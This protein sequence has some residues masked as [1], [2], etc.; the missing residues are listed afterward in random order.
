M[1]AKG[2]L[3][4]NIIIAAVALAVL[5]GGYYFAVQWEPKN[6]EA[7][8]AETADE[9]NDTYVISVEMQDIS[10]LHIKNTEA[11][12]DIVQN[13]DD[14]SVASMNNSD[15][16]RS[17]LKSTIGGLSKLKAVREIKD[18]AS[19][20]ADFGLDKENVLYTIKASDGTEA[21]VLLGNEVPSGGEFYCMV[22]GGD[23]IYTIGS[24]QAGYITKKPDDYR[25][26]SVVS[27]GDVSSI[28]SFA[29]YKDGV[30]VF[31]TVSAAAKDNVNA[32]LMNRWVIEHPWKENA[33]DDKL[34][35]LLNTFASIEAVGFADN[36]DISFDYRVEITAG[37]TEYKLNVG[38]AADGGVYLQNDKNGNIYIVD[39]GIRER[40]EQLNPNDYILKIVALANID[41]VSAVRVKAANGE[42]VLEPGNEDGAPYKINGE[43]VDEKSFKSKYQTVI[44]VLFRERGEFN[45][46][47]EPYMTITYAYKNGSE[48]VVRY[49]EYDDRD[50]V[51]VRND[52]TTVKLLRSE[53]AKIEK[54]ISDK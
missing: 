48:A 19:K 36:A 51:A 9:K 15:I 41:E 20:T 27:I 14:I 54:L 31:K 37:G 26:T 32:S 40:L 30:P 38:G 21:T 12:Y 47:G 33:S 44:G 49:Y 25:I 16:N 6:I 17:A 39:K 45:V 10:V 50:L 29:V 24:S 13:G 4:R 35:E 22:R 46:S 23:R 5:G 52:G 3:I 42:Y 7:D 11:E 18:G 1:S 8:N 28:E 53:A 43:E 34:A 2:R